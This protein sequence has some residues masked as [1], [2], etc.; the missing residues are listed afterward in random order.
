[1]KLKNVI[2]KGDR[3]GRL[4]VLEQL[5]NNQW[6]NRVFLCRCDCGIERTYQASALYRGRA[7]SCGC[8]HKER[9]TKHGDSLTEKTRTSLYKKWSG[10]K[11]RC[12]NSNMQ[13]YRYYGARGITY[14]PEWEDYRNFKE[15]ALSSGYQDGLEIDRIDPDGNY[16]PSNCRW[17]THRQQDYNKRNTL[18]YKGEPLKLLCQR[19]GVD[20]GRVWK[21]IKRDGWSVEKALTTPVKPYKRK[22]TS[23]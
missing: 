21:R 20:Y 17:V 23:L 12:N 9:V 19:L 4:L 5:P 13:D 6:G 18:R 2:N 14:S 16:E 7:Q 10:I 8:L 1:M 11:S 15:W 22:E 3:F